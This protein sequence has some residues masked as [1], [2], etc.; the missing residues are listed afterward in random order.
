MSVQ[1]G[2]V[3]LPNLQVL[4]T[5]LYM[6]KQDCKWRVLLERFGPRHTACMRVK[7]FLRT[8]HALRQDR[9]R[10]PHL[11]PPSP[12]LRRP[13]QRE[14]ALIFCILVQ[15]PDLLEGEVGSD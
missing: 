8:C 7:R 2:N 1:H 9:R 10:L 3:N 11:H 4:N 13:C 12:H 14:R 6:V 15:Y 5:M